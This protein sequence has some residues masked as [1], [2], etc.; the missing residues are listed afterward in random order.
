MAQRN[1]TRRAI[2]DAAMQLIAAGSTPSMAEVAAAAQVSRRT[3][4]MY[5]PTLEQ[6]LIDATLGA[7][8]QN[9]VDAAMGASESRDPVERAMQLSRAINSH[10]A[11]TLHLGR[12]LIR[13][14]VE[15]AEPSA[16]G[17]RRGYRRVQWIEEALKPAR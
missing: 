4:Y 5:F 6:L 3:L 12:A 9:T 7:L 8:S 15:G 16:G 14:T 13:L 11:E 2:V 17:P 1:R 10:S